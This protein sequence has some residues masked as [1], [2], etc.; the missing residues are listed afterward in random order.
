VI[1]VPSRQRAALRSR[2]GYPYFYLWRNLLLPW[3]RAH[4]LGRYRPECPVL[5]L[6]GERKPVMFHSTR[7]L[8][9]V[10]DSGGYAEGIPGAGHWFMETH[11]ETVNEKISDWFRELT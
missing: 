8:E 11:A 4:L 5:F 9:I 3:K 6:F 2:Y 10:A 7:W 1:G